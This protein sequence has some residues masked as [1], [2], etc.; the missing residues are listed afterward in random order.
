MAD[1]R[2]LE[3][4][5]FFNAPEVA[6]RLH[7]IN[8]LKTTYCHNDF[9]NCCRYWIATTLGREHVPAL[10]MPDQMDWARQILQE[11]TLPIH[12]PDQK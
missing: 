11:S 9:E 4:C 8:H 6:D 5:P 12:K 2:F 3:K 1:C 7:L 10:M